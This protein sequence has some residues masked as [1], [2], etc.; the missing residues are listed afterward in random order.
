MEYQ[1]LG[2]SGMNISRLAMGGDML[3][4]NMDKKR[5]AVIKETFYHAFDLGVN[6]FDTAESYGDGFSEEFLGTTLQ[7]I[8]DK[9]F[10]ASKVS[11][12]N[13]HYKDV[14]TACE[15]SLR[16]LNT[17]YIDIYYVHIPNR[18]IPLEETMEAFA[19][20]KETGKIHAVGVSNFSV[21]LLNRALQIVPV[22]VVQTSYNPLWRKIEDDF[23]P[24]CIEQQ[25]AVFPYS[26]L[27]NGLLAGGYEAELDYEKL[28]PAKKRIL[29][30]QPEWYPKCCRIVDAMR[31]IAQ[32]YDRSVAQI[33][34]NWILR[35]KGITGILTGGH[36]PKQVEEN[37]QVFT[38]EMDSDDIQFI[39]DISQELKEQLPYWQSIWFEKR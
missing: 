28:S 13:L 38:F 8:R 3:S 36:T 39:H 19:M 18:D 12:E 29:L 2:K 5:E 25:I 24:F 6:L 21:D 17:D 31:H 35:Q 4:R 11:R 34:L 15:Q 32:K 9:V 1:K 7:P 23:L 16:R 37:N 27:A 10:I 20:L 30:F 26:P 14:I 33:T 22:D